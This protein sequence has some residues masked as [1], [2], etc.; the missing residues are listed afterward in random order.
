MRKGLSRKQLSGLARILA[1]VT[2]IIALVGESVPVYAFED[3]VSDEAYGQAIGLEVAEPEEATDLSIPSA[4]E[5]DILNVQQDSETPEEAS[6]QEDPTGIDEET[7]G[8]AADEDTIISGEETPDETVISEDGE[9]G[10]VIEDET[11]SVEEDGDATVSGN[12]AEETVLEDTVSDEAAMWESIEYYYLLPGEEAFEYHR[13]DKRFDSYYSTY[14]GTTKRKASYKFSGKGI[15]SYKT[16]TKKSD[17]GDKI[18]LLSI[19]GKKAGS[20]VETVTVKSG[21]QILESSQPGTYVVVKPVLGQKSFTINNL[22]D[23]LNLP[24]HIT[25]LEDY[26]TNGDKNLQVAW[27]SSNTKVAQVDQYGKVSFLKTG[28]AKITGTYTNLNSTGKINGKATVTATIK[29]SIPK[30]SKTCVILKVG[31]SAK[32][33]LKNAANVTWRDNEDINTIATVTPSGKNNQTATIKALKP[34]YTFAY[35]DVQ[36]ASGKLTYEVIIGIEDNEKHTFVING[37]S[38]TGKYDYKLMAQMLDKIYQYRLKK[39]LGDTWA[40]AWIKQDVE[41]R[42][43]ELAEGYVYYS[44]SGANY[45]GRCMEW[46]SYS[47]V[48]AAQVFNYFMKDA[49]AKAAMDDPANNGMG[50]YSIKLD[51]KIKVT[52]YKGGGKVV[53]TNHFLI[54]AYGPSN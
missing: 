51:K 36:T 20:T 9:D 43:V 5:E 50:C 1:A 11:A 47:P 16:K 23:T 17:T 24:D 25:G 2:V 41:K 44:P 10:T 49:K 38:Y 32:V 22:N 34:G 18:K 3:A 27:K 29:V 13:E 46:D 40:S 12:E 39:G 31:K 42:V 53:N 52:V 8:E 45:G 15:V 7:A 33:T 37:T 21:K 54:T 14:F 26:N 28:T 4:Q 6:M 30:L 19:T 35:A 48:S